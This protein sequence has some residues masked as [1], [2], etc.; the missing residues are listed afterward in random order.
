MQDVL[1]R[2]GLALMLAVLALLIRAVLPL[3]EGTSIYQLSV[4]AV[5]L[6]AWY[7]GRGPGVFATL[8][9]AIGTLYW[10]VPPRYSFELSPD[11]ALALCIFVALCLFLTEFGAGRRR[12]EHARRESEERFRTFVDRATDAFYLLDDR[13]SVV[14]VNRQACESLGFSREELIGMHPREFDVGLDEATM[15][16]LAQVVGAGQIITFETRHRRKDGSTF[17]VEIRTG[18]FKQRGQLFYLGIARDISE[19]KLAEETL[20]EKDSAL[21]AARTEL[22]R[23]SRLTTLG[24]LTTSIAHEVSQPLGGWSRAPGHPRAGW[25]RT[26]PR[27]RKRAQ[28]STTS[29]PTASGR[30]KSSRGSGRSRSGRCRAMDLLDLQP[31][32]SGSAHPHGAGI[33]QPR[34]RSSDRPGS[35]LP[36]VAG[37]R[38]QLQ[39]V[40]LNLIVNAVEAM[41]AVNDR[42]RELT[43]VSRQETPTPWWS[44]YAIP[45]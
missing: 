11:F 42:S 26:R 23:V 28:R 39:Q 2:Y 40:L 15:K 33:A 41:S 35:T 10:L 3:E 24:E 14:D 34:R 25:Q 37:D 31:R 4:A 38:V 12:N 8:V 7:G 17:P 19:R 21:E 36:R 43:I 5:V 32:D 29:S 9:S 45:A 27:S 44:K 1:K 18:T 16:R 20:R 13:E 22:A 6:S 30:V